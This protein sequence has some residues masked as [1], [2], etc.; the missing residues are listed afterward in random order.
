MKKMFDRLKKLFISK[1][2]KGEEVKIKKIYCIKERRS[3]DHSYERIYDEGRED[4]YDKYTCLTCGITLIYY[5]KGRR[6]AYD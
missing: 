3:T 4:W 1:A 5:D 2:T 6:E